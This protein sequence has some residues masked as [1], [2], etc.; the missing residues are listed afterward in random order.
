MDLVRA[1]QQFHRAVSMRDPG[2]ATRLGG[3]RRT[4]DE[5]WRPRTCQWIEG[6]P[7]DR[8][9][10]GEPVQPGSSYCPKHHAICWHPVPKNGGEDA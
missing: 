5:G 8:G 9:F 6:E 2:M 7:R 10:C 4:R 1:R 3:G